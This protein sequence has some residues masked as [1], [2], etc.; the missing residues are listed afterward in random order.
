MDLAPRKQKDTDQENPMKNF[1]KMTLASC[2]GVILASGVVM[3][4]FFTLL[5]SAVGALVNSFSGSSVTAV[6]P[7]DG[8]VLLLDLEG[9]LSDQYTTDYFEDLFNQGR[10]KNFALPEILRAIA[11]AEDDPMVEAI[12]LKL[13]NCNMGF[14][15][16]HQLRDALESFKQS[17]KRIYAYSDLFYGYGNYYVSS[18]A[19]KIFANPKAT[20]GITGLGSTVLFQRGLLEKLGVKM[21]VYKV[22]TFKGAVEPYVLDKLSDANRMQ[23]QTYLDG[24]WNGTLSQI[25]SSRNIST[26]VL[27]NF[28]DSALFLKGIEEAVN[29]DLID[30]LVY[31]TDLD[32][33]LA[34]EVL[35]DENADLNIL[36]VND[37]LSPTDE[38]AEGNIAILYA[39]GNIVDLKP[40]NNPFESDIKQIDPRV[41]EQLAELAEDDDVDAVVFRIN[42][43]G[44]SARMSELI[45]REVIRLKAKKPIVVSMGDYAASGG[46]YI[47]SNATKILADPYTLTGSIGIFGLVPNFTGTAGKIGLTHDTVKT[48]KM[49]DFMS[50]L[51]PSTAE[52]KAVMQEMIEKGYDEFLTRVAQGRNLTKKQVD[53]IAQGRVWLGSDALEIGLVDQLGNL[54]DAVEEA[55]NLA[56]L[57]NYTITDYTQVM[58]WT[59]ALFGFDLGKTVRSLMLSPEERAMRMVNKLTKE[60][61]G[62]QAVPPYPLTNI[63]MENQELIYDLGQ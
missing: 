59:E 23:I 9:T 22:G 63:R 51:R 54:Q 7:T 56:D 35:G 37:L 26:E 43:G 15:S 4:L 8:S 32:G 18:V 50:P 3:I 58:S 27:Q 13:E 10:Q 57:S 53:S 16:A 21:E 49:A 44:G 2:L 40:E 48:A 20:L 1:L 5:S 36:R 6:T 45:A 52:E 38:K 42:S 24:L 62:I 14:A 30:S 31:E 29:R 41:A 19:D 25:A 28:A 34:K 47:A 55:A 11:A 33:I 46:Y 61:S 12:I 17:G 39:E 60:M